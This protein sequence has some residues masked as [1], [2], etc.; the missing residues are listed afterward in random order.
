MFLAVDIGNTNITLGVFDDEKLVQT[1][2]L[3]SDVLC[4]QKDCEIRLKSLL[5]DFEIS[6]CAVVSVVKELSEKLK[7]ACDNVFGI[8]SR[9]FTSYK[10]FDIKIGIQSPETI[11]ADRLANVCAV[12]G[13][14]RPVIVVDIGTAIT[15]D[16][17]SKDGVF[18]GGVIMPGVN[19]QFKALN[20]HTSKLPLL[21]YE[22]CN[23]AIGD[24]TKNAMLS[25]VIRGT[26]CAI[27]GLIKQ[28]ETE[29]K[30]P[31]IIIATGGQCGLVSEYMSRKFDVIDSNLTLEGVR[32]LNENRPV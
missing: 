24:C 4:E 31:S 6:S 28:C 32:L 27:E 25:G 19:L 14:N 12:K 5:T 1:F 3:E 13:Y 29:L 15:F 7:L 20:Q 16:I 11:G 22:P 26:A 9:L 30:E 23:C 2:R 18:L 8:N 21:E 17:L 10:D